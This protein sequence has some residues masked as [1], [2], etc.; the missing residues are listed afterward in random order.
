M[1]DWIYVSGTILQ[2]I[3]FTMGMRPTTLGLALAVY[4]AGLWWFASRWH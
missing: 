3:A 2:L 4:G 1:G